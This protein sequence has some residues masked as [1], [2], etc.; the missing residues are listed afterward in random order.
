MLLKEV[1]FQVV[2][3]GG[4]G[5]NLCLMSEGGE[6]QRRWAR[7]AEVLSPLMEVHRRKDGLRKPVEL[8][9]SRGDATDGRGSADDTL[10]LRSSL[11]QLDE[12]VREPEENGS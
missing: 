2:F 7:V 8:V 9:W 10:Q 6:L 5:F 3:E 11:D 4:R 12:F 1:S